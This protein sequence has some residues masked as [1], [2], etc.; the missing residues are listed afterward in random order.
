MGERKKNE[1][2][3]KEKRRRRKRRKKRIKKNK[4]WASPKEI[5]YFSSFFV[6]L[7]GS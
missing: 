3:T 1:G 5:L 6:F 4:R 2:E 7:G